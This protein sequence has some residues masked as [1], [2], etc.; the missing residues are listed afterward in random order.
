MKIDVAVCTYQSEKY[1]D[2]CLMSVEKSVHINKLI[3]V[4]PHIVLWN[5]RYWLQ[6]LPGYLTPEKYTKMRRN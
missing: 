2:E 3:V 1:L 6:Y 4:D 5:S